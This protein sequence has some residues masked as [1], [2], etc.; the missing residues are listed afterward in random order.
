MSDIREYRG[1]FKEER[2]DAM[3]TFFG[4][5]FG[6]PNK[7]PKTPYVFD[8]KRAGGGIGESNEAMRRPYSP[9][10]VSYRGSQGIQVLRSMLTQQQAYYIPNNA[11]TL[12]SGY[13]FSDGPNVTPD[14]LALYD[15]AA[16][17]IV[18]VGGS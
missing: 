10:L 4:F 6:R 14:L 2:S 5:L 15:P 1:D 11:K 8:A 16:T 13:G 7:A 9:P 3:R 17:H 12:T 18:S